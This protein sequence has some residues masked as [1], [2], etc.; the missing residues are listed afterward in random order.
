MAA[1]PGPSSG[2]SSVGGVRGPVL[3]TRTSGATPPRTTR[4]HWPPR[5]PVRTVIPAVAAGEV[6]V[7][8]AGGGGRRY[9]EQS[10]GATRVLG[11]HRS[12]G[13]PEIGPSPTEPG[14]EP[15]SSGCI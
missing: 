1:S 6:R 11:V 2:S 14:G 12:R 13:P 9:H 8:T 10:A 4:G 3:H 7:T 15:Q 5:A